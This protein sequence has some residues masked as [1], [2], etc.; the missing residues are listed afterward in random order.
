MAVAVYNDS[1][2]AIDYSFRFA[3]VEQDVHWLMHSEQ[4]RYLVALTGERF[5][6]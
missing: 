5:A 4:L 2:L 6:V 1:L 3:S